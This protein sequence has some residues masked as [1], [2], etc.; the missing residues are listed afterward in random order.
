M[1][2]TKSRLLLVLEQ[3]IEDMYQ[4]SRNPHL[5]A[6]DYRHKAEGAV[7]FLEGL[8]VLTEQE[9]QSKC[10]EIKSRWS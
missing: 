9:R 5:R 1:N 8:G 2:F 3:H 6:D 7:W 4:V 10:E